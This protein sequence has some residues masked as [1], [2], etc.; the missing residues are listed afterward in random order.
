[1]IQSELTALTFWDLTFHPFCICGLNRTCLSFQYCC[2]I[3][4]NKL[5]QWDGEENHLEKVSKDHALQLVGKAIDMFSTSDECHIV[6]SNGSVQS[7]SYLTQK[8]K[9]PIEDEVLPAEAVIK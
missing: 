3:N 6:F 2:V 1:M 9:M 8:K 7:V 4:D 5:I